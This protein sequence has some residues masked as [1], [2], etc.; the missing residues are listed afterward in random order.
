MIKAS[1]VFNE[2]ERSERY[3]GLMKR[4][5]KNEI[6]LIADTLQCVFAVLRIFNSSI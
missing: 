6:S 4:K 2:K 1:F 3:E 5:A